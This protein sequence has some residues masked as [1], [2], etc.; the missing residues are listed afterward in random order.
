MNRIGFYVLLIVYMNKKLFLSLQVI[1]ED[2]LGA[3]EDAESLG[4]PLDPMDQTLFLVMP[5][6]S[7]TDIDPNSHLIFLMAKTYSDVSN[8]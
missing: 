3:I 7:A 6:E 1:P 2:F 4:K 5:T 8:E